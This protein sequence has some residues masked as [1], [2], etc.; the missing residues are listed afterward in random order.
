MDIEDELQDLKRKFSLLEGDRKAFYESSQLSMKQ[1]REQ[2]TLLKSESKQLRTALRDA[3][4]ESSFHPKESSLG[5]SASRKGS[6]DVRGSTPGA[7]ATTAFSSSGVNVHE[8]EVTKLE[9]QLL[10]LRR[11]YDQTVFE[12]QQKSKS[13]EGLRDEVGYLERDATAATILGTTSVG[14]NSNSN[15]NNSASTNLHHTSNNNN[16]ATSGNLGAPGTV[17]KEESAESTG[18]QIRMLENRLDKAMIK[19]NEAQSI[20]K[21]YEQIVK[22]LKEERIG[23][24]HQLAAIE[25]TLKAKER[26]LEELKLMSHDATHARDVARAELAGFKH[27]HDEA[28]RVRERELAERRAYVE[29]KVEQTKKMQQQSNAANSGNANGKDGKDS[30]S[31]EEKKK[32]QVAD[33]MASESAAGARAREEESL[34]SNYEEMFRKIKEATGVSDVNEVISKFMTQ[35]DTQKSLEETC[36]E[37]QTKVD[38]LGEERNALKSRLEEVKYSGTANAGSRRIVDEFE[39]QLADANAVCERNRQKYE[40]LAKILINVKA[41]IEHLQDKLEVLRSGNN[42]TAAAA[43]KK[44]SSNGSAQNVGQNPDDWP[45]PVPVSDE[46]VVQA[47]ALCEQKIVWLRQKIAE[48]QQ[49]IADSQPQPQPQAA[50]APA[51]PADSSPQPDHAQPQSTA[52]SSAENA[53]ASSATGAESAGGSSASAAPASEDAAAPTAATAPAPTAAAA[54]STPTASG[55]GSEPE[56]PSSP[57]K[58]T[59]AGS[60]AAIASD[61]SAAVP[62]ELPANNVR[63]KLPSTMGDDDEESGD[64]DDD[65]EVLNRETV[66]RLAAIAVEKATKKPKKKKTAKKAEKKE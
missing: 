37:Q 52:G 18:R 33:A 30:N 41:G 5:P 7:S 13:V 20:R 49:A 3:Q 31:E 66:K 35:E 1:N 46:T 2:L 4:R 51:A 61:S 21:T 16:N 19:F 27:A 26:D 45:E 62:M 55:A 48:I 11:A 40:R 28:K 44:K 34:L 47:L 56:K 64:S 22:R 58:M 25:R 60:S 14:A 15:N 59:R 63:I 43:G 38:A 10:R 8:M 53:Q 57:S 42:N 36:K 12:R 39:S 17:S 24:D 29:A 54:S 65:D 9:A 6:S 23:F 32:K 50:A